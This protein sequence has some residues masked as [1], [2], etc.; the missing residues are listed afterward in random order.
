M[1]L[2]EPLLL[3]VLERGGRGNGEA[4]EEYV[5]LR[6]GER[7][8]PVVILLT[9]VGLVR[10]H[11]RTWSDLPAVSNRPKVYGSSPIMTV[12]A[13]VTRQRVQIGDGNNGL[14][15]P[16]RILGV[17]YSQLSNTVGTYSEGNLFVVYEIRRHVLKAIS[18][19][20][21]TLDSL[22]LRLTFRRLHRQQQHI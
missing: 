11:S 6:V 13:S 15:S 2:W 1:N 3:H 14:A 17:R 4:D 22:N 7:A 16:C 12:T 19:F 18:T 8:E 21:L 10:V 20:D 5:G 9:C